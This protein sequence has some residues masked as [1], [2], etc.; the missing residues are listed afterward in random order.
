MHTY[1]NSKA[2]HTMQIAERVEELLSII[3]FHNHINFN[4]DKILMGFTLICIPIFFPF[5]T[6]NKKNIRCR[7]IAETRMLFSC[8]IINKQFV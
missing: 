3:W 4:A 5:S 1:G 7:P 6:R 2:L 8:R